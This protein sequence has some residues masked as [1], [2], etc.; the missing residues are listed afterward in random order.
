MLGTIEGGKLGEEGM[1]MVNKT[2][3]GDEGRGVEERQANNMKHG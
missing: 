3:V 1:M 2:G